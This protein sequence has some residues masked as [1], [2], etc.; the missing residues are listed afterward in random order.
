MLYGIYIVILV[1]GE[2]F[3]TLALTKKMCGS[4]QWVSALLASLIPWLLIFGVV[5]VMLKIFPGWLS[6]FSNTFG[7]GIAKIAGLSKLTKQLFKSKIDTDSQELKG[8][9]ELLANI[10]GD[11]SLLMNEITPTNFYEFWKKLSPLFKNES[12]NNMSLKDSLF[13]IIRIKQMVSE[14]IW[15]LLTG[16]LVTSVSYNY[17]VN[18]SCSNSVKDMQ[19][20]ISGLEDSQETDPETRV[21]T[22]NE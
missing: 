3:T 7:Y 8:V 19:Q 6:P 2:Y 1:I 15:Y 22:T 17:V 14:Y 12:K 9:Q 18:T 16:L 20:R 11:Q 10:Y 21:Y 4:H 13:N 5:N